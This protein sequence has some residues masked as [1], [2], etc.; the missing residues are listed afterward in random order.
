MP[1]ECLRTPAK[2]SE[3]TCPVFGDNEIPLESLLPKAYFI[4]KDV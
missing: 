3:K 1:M 4:S 2:Q